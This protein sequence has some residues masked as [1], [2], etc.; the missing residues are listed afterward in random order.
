MKIESFHHGWNVR[1]RF[2]DAKLV[3]AWECGV[4]YT[5]ETNGKFYLIIDEGTL[6]DFMDDPLLDDLVKVY[7]FDTEQERTEWANRER[8]V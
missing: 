5:A 2:P 1:G 6:A 7:E 8:T 4:S 3:Y